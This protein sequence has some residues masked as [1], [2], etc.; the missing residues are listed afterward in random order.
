M[1]RHE[2]IHV[3]NCLRARQHTLFDVPHEY[4]APTHHIYVAITTPLHA[5]DVF[6][7]HTKSA[8]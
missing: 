7:P 4:D 8:M 5:R 1:S 6:L 2:G 3:N